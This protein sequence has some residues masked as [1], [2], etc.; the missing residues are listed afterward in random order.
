MLSEANFAPTAT[1]PV[2]RE[3]AEVVQGGARR[4]MLPTVPR[5]HRFA[6][7][8]LVRLG[9]IKSLDPHAFLLLLLLLHLASPS[10]F[11]P[12]G[13]R[14]S[15]FHMILA[16]SGHDGRAKNAPP[17]SHRPIRTRSLDSRHFGGSAVA[18]A[19]QR[20]IGDAAPRL[21]STCSTLISMR[22]KGSTSAKSA[23]RPTVIA[24]TRSPFD[25]SRT[26]FVFDGACVLC[27][28]GASRLMRLDLRA[29]LN[30]ASMRGSLGTALYRH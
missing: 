15:G 7:T 3:G 22:S 2:V 1:Q 19:R 26:L 11:D 14:R 8:Y 21:V 13:S 18:T 29:K 4:S 10:L 17:P 12:L 20:T 24:P 16:G 30:L 9:F 5:A 23:L 28:G 25:D 27:S 6:P